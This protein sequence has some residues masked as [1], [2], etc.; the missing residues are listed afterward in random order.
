MKRIYFTKDKETILTDE[1]L[2]EHES[3][4]IVMSNTEIVGDDISFSPIENFIITYKSHIL[5]DIDRVN[6][7][8][9][10]VEEFAKKY[11][12]Y[13]FKDKKGNI[14]LASNINDDLIIDIFNKKMIY[15]RSINDRYYLWSPY[16][17]AIIDD[18]FVQL[19][20]FITNSKKG[21]VIIDENEPMKPFKIDTNAQSINRLVKNDKYFL[22][23][24]KG[25]AILIPIKYTIIPRS[26]DIII[27]PNDST[28]MILFDGN[29]LHE[30]KLKDFH[31][32]TEYTISEDRVSIDRLRYLGSS[33]KRI[34]SFVQD[35]NLLFTI[36]EET[37]KVKYATS[38]T[39]YVIHNNKLY[40]TQDGKLIGIYSIDTYDV[41]FEDKSLLVED[42]VSNR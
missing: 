10:S 3:L 40:L 17:F 21:F 39:D 15:R 42:D 1:V 16:P 36:D 5:D 32:M 12:L 8:K 35:Y 24:Y 4:P 7:E 22:Y 18:V 14:Y 2:I 25:N 11:G 6:D 31:A 20:L 38:Q 29:K 34:G 19:E 23:N 13:G 41:I 27:K 26:T 37:K 28:D 30:V 33:A 9:M